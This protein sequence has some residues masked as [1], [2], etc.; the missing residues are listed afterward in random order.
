MSLEPRAMIRCYSAVRTLALITVCMSLLSSTGCA[1]TGAVASKDAEQDAKRFE[2]LDGRSVIYI[3]RADKF[4]GSAVLMRCTVD[5]TS[6]TSLGPSNFAVTPVEPGL[7]TIWTEMGGVTP[8]IPA[9][10]TLMTSPG[11]NY[12]VRAELK[13]A[14]LTTNKIEQAEVPEEIA[15]KELKRFRLVEWQ[16]GP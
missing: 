8:P 7:H 3:Y 9:K 2:R 6:I 14:N 13:T 12:F 5:T 16:S 10:T 11:E 15:K 1:T 4:F